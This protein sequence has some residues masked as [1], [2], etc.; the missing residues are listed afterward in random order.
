MLRRT[1]ARLFAL[2][3]LVTAPVLA[4]DAIDLRQRM[5]EHRAV[6]EQELDETA[7]LVAGQ[8]AGVLA[9]GRDLLRVVAHW[10]AMRN[11]DDAACSR[12][13][14]GLHPQFAN[15]T[16]FSRVDASGMITCSSTPVKAPVDVSETP[17]IRAAL[18]GAPGISDF[19]FGPLTGKPVIVVSQPVFDDHGRV[20]ASV[21][22]GVNLEWLSS[23]LAHANLTEGDRVTV[24]D[25]RGRVLAAW[26]EGAVAPGDQ[27]IGQPIDRR[28]IGA[29]FGRTGMFGIAAVEAIPGGAYVV[30]HRD[31]AATLAPYREALLERA[32]LLLVVV[33]LSVLL[34]LLAARHMVLRWTETLG[35]LARSLADGDYTA[36]SQLRSDGSEL[37]RLAEDC[38]AMAVA[39]ERRRRQIERHRRMLRRA[40]RRAHEASQAKSQF[41]AAMSHELRTP[42]NAIL[43]YSEVVRD[44]HLGPGVADRYAE[45]ADHIHSSGRHLLALIDDLLDVAKIEAGKMQLRPETLEIGEIL[46]ECVDGMREV[47]AGRGVTLAAAPPD[48]GCVVTADPTALRRM[49]YNLLSNAVKYTPPGGSVRIGWRHHDDAWELSVA[50]DGPGIPPEQI[51]RVLRPF[52]Q[53]DNRI[54]A[55]PGTGLGLTLVGEL[56]RAHGGAL[57]IDSAPGRGTTARI[58]LPAEAAAEAVA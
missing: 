40:I 48:G 29:H 38:D 6:V 24:L 5:D 9:S 36:R 52:E 2:C 17:H 20:T 30:L 1:S 22:L 55:Q 53:L 18:A 42:L 41:L 16:N 32:S 49:A 33:A 58:R 44:R 21:N 25:G 11:G 7:R 51:D 39:L 54:G 12:A 56:A 19:F 46:R 26:P 15:I 14:A 47:A 43:G 23:S 8:I 37:G 4:Y 34:A 31:R 50:D 27:L 13:L 35:R 45:Y 3:L 57:A 10:D 28:S